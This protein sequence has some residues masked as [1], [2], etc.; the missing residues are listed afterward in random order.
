M[1][2]WK[3]I[4]GLAAALALAAGCSRPVLKEN[5]QPSRAKDQYLRVKK[6]AVFPFENYTETKDADKTID[7]LVI[8]ALRDE[9]VFDVVEDTRFTRD[10]MKKL[11]IT[12]TEILDKEVLKK[13]SDE[14]NVQGIVYGKIL[15]YGK[16]KDKDS[17]SQVTMD[18]A[19]VEPST[20]N[21]LW[22]GNVST[23]G[24]LTAGKVF[25]VTEGKTDIEVAREAVQRLASSLARAV[26]KAQD[27][28]RK[29]IVAELKKEE[30]I[31][32]AR[33]DKLRGE[34]GKIQEQM[35]KAK[36]EAKGI[37]DA[38]SKE[39]EGIKS[40]LEMQKAALEAEK[41]K[42]T[43]A[44]QE[45]DQEKL[46]VELEKKKIADEM[47]KLAEEKKKLEEEKKKAAEAIKEERVKDAAPA[48]PSPPA[49]APP[50]AAPPAP[51]PG[52]PAGAPTR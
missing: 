35:D 51:A 5:A 19:L 50:P 36:T 42:T 47:K 10:V 3:K 18:M 38:A 26:K 13:L 17:A 41:A 11:K 32:K 7:A 33:L 20:G 39:A 21:A 28:E 24:G 2:A 27:R 49:P 34:T 31:E 15:N 14:M 22:V 45:I 6:V 52:E 43:S 37:R 12:S 30:E 48:V 23:Y 9:G 44:Q 46:K 1:D 4:V 29:G 8:P 40:E 16:G 25:G